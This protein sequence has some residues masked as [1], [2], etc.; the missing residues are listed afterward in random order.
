MT[1]G[2]LFSSAPNLP[3]VPL[4]APGEALGSWVAVIADLYGLSRADYLERLG[5]PR[6]WVTEAIDRDLVFRPL[7]SVMTRL[8]ADTGIAEDVLRQMTFAGLDRPLEDAC[9]C[10]H[11]PC[12]E[13]NYEAARRAGR[14]VDLLFA[15]A[16]WRV[17]CPHHLPDLKPMEIAAQVPLLVFYDQARQ[18]IAFLDRAAYDQSVFQEIVG[19][20]LAPAF[21]ADVFLWFVHL[22]N[23][24]LSVQVADVDTMRERSEFR[25]LSVFE[26]DTDSRPVPLPEEM[27]NSLAVSLVLAWQFVTAPYTTLF[28]GLRTTNPAGGKTGRDQTQFTAL[29]RLLLEVWPGEVLAI[30]VLGG[31]MSVRRSAGQHAYTVGAEA[32]T[33]PWSND[34]SHAERLA[35]AHWN[36]VA[37]VKA[38]FA[39]PPR[40]QSSG[41]VSQFPSVGPFGHRPV[42]ANTHAASLIARKRQAVWEKRSLTPSRRAG[43]Q[44]FSEALPSRPK[45]P[46]AAFV[47]PARTLTISPHIRDAV[48][49]VLAAYGPLPG[50]LHP[51]ERRAL[52]RK[53]SAAAIKHLS[54]GAWQVLSTSQ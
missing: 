22:L 39:D 35:E 19:T 34:P 7:P 32:V 44:R 3:V 42:A 54:L 1:G 31:A 27:C 36:H 30:P 46:H 9:R 13:C 29:I 33:K 53:L 48:E 47:D 18:A 45:E 38:L 37:W 21:S 11:A 8:Q 28:V 6:R 51:R 24:F 17:V 16:A 52:L 2:P 40:S 25:I 50:K 23:V 14:P 10:H 15:R 43:L 4:P 12:P 5:V 41:Y 20:R 49:Q 26:E